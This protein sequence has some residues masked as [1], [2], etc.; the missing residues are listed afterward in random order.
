MNSLKKIYL[1]LDGFNQI[2]IDPNSRQINKTEKN[3]YES[4]LNTKLTD[5]DKNYEVN[6]REIVEVA[7]LSNTIN[8]ITI[9]E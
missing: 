6:K 3:I 5:I 7:N 4:T 2:E 1:T 9:Y 8:S